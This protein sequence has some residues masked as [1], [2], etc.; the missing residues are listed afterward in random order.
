MQICSPEIVKKLMQVGRERHPCRWDNGE[1]KKRRRNDA[2]KTRV[3]KICLKYL[4]IRGDLGT[5]LRDVRDCSFVNFS[6]RFLGSIDEPVAYSR[7]FF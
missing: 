7:T 6:A 3:Y 1:K 4:G 2:V 5:L